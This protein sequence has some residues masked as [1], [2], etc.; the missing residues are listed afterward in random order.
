MHVDARANRHVLPKRKAE[1]PEGGEEGDSIK[2]CAYEL[3]TRIDGIYFS[4]E[5]KCAYWVRTSYKY[6]NRVK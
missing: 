4:G 1:M 5:R 6:S 2:E 3:L